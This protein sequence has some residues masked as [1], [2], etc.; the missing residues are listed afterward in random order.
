METDMRNTPWI[1]LPKW[2]FFSWSYMKPKDA[3]LEIT[4]RFFSIAWDF[5]CSTLI[6]NVLLL[7]LSGGC[8]VTNCECKSILSTFWLWEIEPLRPSSTES[9]S[10]SRAN[11]IA[12]HVWGSDHL[13]QGFGTFHWAVRNPLKVTVTNYTTPKQADAYPELDCATLH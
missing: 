2:C 11:P 5:L 6:I 13:S 7:M 4:K 8:K 9:L 10:G 12:S 1:Q 3:T